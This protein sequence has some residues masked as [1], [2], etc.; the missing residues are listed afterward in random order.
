MRRA[1]RILGRVL[2][3]ILVVVIVSL[4]I[5]ALVVSHNSPC[6]AAAAAPAGDTRMKA[7]LYRCYGPPEVVKLEETAKPVPKDNQVLIRVRA[8]SVNPYDWHFMRGSPYLVRLLVGV[9]TP[10]DPRLGVDFAG[11]IEAVG[12]DVKRFRV[13]DEV[14]GGA[15]GAFGQYVAI[16]EGGSLAA[17]PTTA[18][19]EQAAAIPI[20]GITALQGMRDLGHVR[21]GQKVLI[22]GAS[23]GVGTYAVQIAKAYGAEV[24]GVCSTRNVE[25]VRALGADHVLDYTREDFTRGPERDDVIF[26]TVGNRSFSDYARV[27]KPQ[28]TYIVAGGP[29]GDWIGPMMGFIKVVLLGPFMHQRFVA[30]SAQMNQ[31]DLTEL[32][33]LMQ[34]G[35]IMSVIDRSYPL[36][37]ISTAIAYLETGHARGKV[38]ID[39]D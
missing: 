13:G 15:D 2:S 36:G 25:M 30:L 11:T 29:P 20:A 35:K 10:K 8:A 18:N 5:L 17:K 27:L 32:A 31:A 4:L 21:P 39:V 34:S 33:A 9:G 23:G 19:F 14:F 22:N 6:P 16:R 24:T 7:A 37:N 3:A 26:D 28:G 38:V 1:M 12:K